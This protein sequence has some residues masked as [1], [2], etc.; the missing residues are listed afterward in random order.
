MSLRSTIISQ[1]EAVASEQ[2]RP[3]PPLADDLQLADSGL[4]SLSFAIIVVRLE[5]ALGFDPFS[6]AEALEFPTRFGDFVAVY[7]KFGA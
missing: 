7:E 3:L 6:A 5:E 4:D 1:F 2:N